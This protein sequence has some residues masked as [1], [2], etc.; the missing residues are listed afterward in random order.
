MIRAAT[1]VSPIR[2]Y[3]SSVGS[4]PS[5]RMKRTRVEILFEDIQGATTNRYTAESSD[6]GF[7]LR[8]TA[9]YTDPHSD[10]DDTMT[11]LRGRTHIHNW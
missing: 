2:A 10:A 4:G 11:P 8:A 1:W 5:P 3:T 9:T 7:Y 6:R